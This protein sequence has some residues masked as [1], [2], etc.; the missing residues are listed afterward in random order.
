MTK[1]EVVNLINQI[2][3]GDMY[4]PLSKEEVEALETAVIIIEE[5]EDDYR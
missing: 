3:D 2:L 5:A 4:D 1:R